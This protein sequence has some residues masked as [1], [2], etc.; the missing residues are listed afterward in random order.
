MSMS[1]WMALL[2]V[3]REWLDKE[4]AYVDVQSTDEHFKTQQSPRF[5]SLKAG[6]ISEYFSA[7]NS[8][9]KLNHRGEK[10]GAEGALLKGPRNI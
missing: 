2:P 1:S 7:E 9:K 6:F 3:R 10:S 5:Q 8:W 4:A